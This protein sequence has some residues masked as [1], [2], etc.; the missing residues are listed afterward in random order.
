M[1]SL[2]E[3]IISS[4]KSGLL[5]TDK[6]NE[7]LWDLYFDAFGDMIDKKTA[8]KIPWSINGYRTE[9]YFDWKEERGEG[10]LCSSD[11]RHATDGFR[12]RLKKLIESLK[13]IKVFK[14]I[15]RTSNAIGKYDYII[16]LN[17]IPKDWQEGSIELMFWDDRN[18]YI[19]GIRIWGKDNPFMNLLHPNKL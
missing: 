15:I 14:E 18:K 8:R 3:S 2:K 17:G 16:Y 10:R 5:N 1:K 12:D 6:F 9:I 4:N 11:W 13:K 19:T 7:V